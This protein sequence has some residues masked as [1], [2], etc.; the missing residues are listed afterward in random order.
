VD[1]PAERVRHPADL[2]RDE[3]LPD[4]AES[5]AAEL[6]RHVHRGQAELP[7]L[8]IVR[9]TDLA[10]DR[11]LVLLGMDLPGDQLLVD[12]ST[13]ALLDLAIGSGEAQRHGR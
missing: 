6:L 7:R 1:A 5:A 4:H 10:G 12:E 2:L 9:V 8:P 11:S 3:D 13:G